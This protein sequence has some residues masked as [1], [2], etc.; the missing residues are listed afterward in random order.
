ME[1]SAA[2]LRQAMGRFATGVTVL[3]AVVDGRVHAMTANAVTSVSL[4]PPL[5][6]ASV[7]AHCQWRFAARAAGGYSIHVLADDQAELARWCASAER[8][9]QPDRLPLLPSGSTGH[10][11]LAGV[12]ATIDCRT[13][14]EYPAGDHDLLIGE[15]VAV[16]VSVDGEPLVFAE[17]RFG[18]FRPTVLSAVRDAIVVADFPVED[19]FPGW[20]TPVDSGVATVAG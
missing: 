1:V 6:L 9:E 5:V 20:T 19:P 14:A 16:E 8:H 17:R 15:V 4:D 11:R 12:L 13:Y 18:G 7:S 10:A 3:T 2:E